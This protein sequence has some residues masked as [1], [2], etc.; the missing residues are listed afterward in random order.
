M[1]WLWVVMFV[2]GSCGSGL[3]EPVPFDWTDPV[4]ID[5]DGGLTV[6]PCA[7][8][9]DAPVA[10]LS[11]NGADLALIEHGTAPLSSFPDVAGGSGSREALEIITTGYLESFRADRRAGCPDWDFLATGP[12]PATVALGEGRVVGFTLERDGERTELSE[13]HFVISGDTVHWLTIN[14]WHAAT[15][16][17]PDGERPTASPGDWDG[18]LTAF[19]LVASGS[20]T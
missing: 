11:R 10:C 19:R 1:R 13:S 14:L 15:A 3:G 5:L 9:G 6:G 20:R 12:E 8:G 18:I 2:M 4:P 16:C 17:L 7:G